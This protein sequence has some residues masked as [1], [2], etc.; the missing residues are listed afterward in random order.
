MTKKPGEIPAF[1]IF[2]YS[3]LIL[4]QRITTFKITFNPQ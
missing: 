1:L 3:P 2:R 4:I